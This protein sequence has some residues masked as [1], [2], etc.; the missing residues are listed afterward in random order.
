MPFRAALEAKAIAKRLPVVLLLWLVWCGSAAPQQP[1]PGNMSFA[2]IGDVPYNDLEDLA[3]DGLIQEMNRQN[4]A[5]VVHVGDITSSH[6]PCSDE[7]FQARH[8]QFEKSRHP[9][10]VLP[11]D[12]DWIDCRRSGFDPLERLARFRQLFHSGDESLG[13]RTLRLERQSSDPRFS[14]YREHIRWVAGNVLFVGL[15]VP[16]NNN[17]LGRTPPMDDEHRQRMTAVLDWL[18]GAMKI[19]EHKRL[20][21]VVILMH[22]NPGFDWRRRPRRGVPDG[23]L[24]LRHALSA[25]ALWLKRPILLVHGD[26]HRYQQNRPLTDPS[27]G[28]RIDNLTRVEV[29]GSPQVH[30][31]LATVDPGNPAVFRVAPAPPSVP[32]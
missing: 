18:D 25:H 3:L 17:N 6:G 15:N 30:W 12:N 8:R 27:T 11:G 21:G 14:D 31:V 2:L 26:T 1:G 7:W 9:L 19:A 4:L 23:F 20:S 22:A 24:E 16:G 10:I 5:F 29:F 32:Q 13:Q 28:K